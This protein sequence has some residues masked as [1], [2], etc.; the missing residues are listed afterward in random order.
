[1]VQSRGMEHTEENPEL[2]VELFHLIM[3]PLDMY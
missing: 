2:L 1:M 3:V